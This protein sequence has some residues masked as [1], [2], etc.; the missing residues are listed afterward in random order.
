MQRFVDV[1]RILGAPPAAPDAVEVRGA[2][3]REGPRQDRRAG[4]VRRP[5]AVEA[6]ERV[7]E[8]VVRLGAIAREAEA[9]AVETGRERLVELPE[10]REVP[11]GITLHDGVERPRGARERFDRTGERR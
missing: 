5:R 1:E 9:E 11:R 6:Q 8:E 4:S 2:R 10:G 3:D 7:L